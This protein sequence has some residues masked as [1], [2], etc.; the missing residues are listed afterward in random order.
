V[1]DFV[2]DSVGVIVAMYLSSKIAFVRINY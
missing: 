2:A 1:L